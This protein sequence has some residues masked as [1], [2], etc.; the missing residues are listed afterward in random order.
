[1]MRNIFD[2]PC[3]EPPGARQKDTVEN[4]I[5]NA[6]CSNGPG[7]QSHGT[8]AQSSMTLQRGQEILSRDWYACYVTIK[9][10][11]VTKKRD[12][13]AIISLERR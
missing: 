6:I 4:Y 9:K 3:P 11:H 5:H 12:L 7:R 2:S 13:L 1:M 10:G 8:E